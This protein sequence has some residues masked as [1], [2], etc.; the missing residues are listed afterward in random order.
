MAPEATTDLVISAGEI[1]KFGYCALNWWLYRQGVEGRDNAL[2]LGEGRHGRLAATLEAI[3]T[4]EERAKDEERVVLYLAVASTIL[5][6]L[7]LMVLKAWSIALGQTL[8]VVALIWLL[9]AIY[10]LYRAEVVT[11]PEEKLLSERI[12]VAFA[13]AATLAALFSVSTAFVDDAGLG[14]VLEVLALL[15]LILASLFLYR[16]LAH[17]EGARKARAGAAVGPGAVEYLDGRGSAVLTSRR[18]GLSGK[19][20]YVLA[21]DGRH[22]PVEFKGGRTPRGPLFSHILQVAAYC[23]LLEEQYGLPV[24]YGVLRY[25]KV[26]HEIDF[27]PELRELLLNK[28]GEMRRLAAAGVVHRNHNRPGKC[29]GCSRRYACPE[30]LA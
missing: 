30:K 13:M 25:G 29:V 6:L 21:V 15:W 9:A 22:I 1:E 14:A 12:L 20:D 26:H 3:R 16:S 27:S 4:G 5:S 19:P 23:L 7:G 10:F 17:L 11:I 18:Y 24:P 28:L 2:A 8:A